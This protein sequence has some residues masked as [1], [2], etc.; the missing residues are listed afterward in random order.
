M[1]V[2]LNATDNR[3]RGG[4][5]DAGIRRPSADEAHSDREGASM[6]A[7]AAPLTAARKT[8]GR[9]AVV[10]IVVVAV[11]VVGVAA[12]T[13]LRPK[14]NANSQTSTTKVERK[15]IRVVV[16]GT[17]STVVVDSV[18]VNPQISGTVE[19][20]YVSLGET[21]TAG[22]DLYTISSPSV[23]TKLLQSKASLLQSKQSLKQSKQSHQQAKNT[24]Y[25]AKTSQIQAQQSLDNLESQAATTS[26]LENQITV[27]ERQLK[28]AK[29]AVTAAS[30]G[31]SAA[32]LGVSASQA[33]V[34]SAQQSYDDAL[35]DTKDTVV[36]APIDGVVTALPISVGS[37]VSAGTNTSSGSSGSSSSSSGGTAGA[38]TVSTGSS[39]SSSGSLTISNVGN[40]KVQVA[41]SEVDVPKL[42]IGQKAEVTF[43]AIADKLFTG[44]VALISPNGTSSSGV[45]NYDVDIT[46]DTQDPSLKPD[47]TATA[48]ILTQ[49]AENV[50]VVPNAAVKSDGKTK[51]VDAVGQNG[52]SSR[53]TVVVGVSDET[54][55]EIK[56]GLTEGAT[57]STGG[58]TGVSKTSTSGGGFMMGG[59][60]PGGGPGGN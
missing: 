21:V 42:Q 12:F 45:V 37:D 43:D 46:L 34:N 39:S 24:L 56:S 22:E 55:T 3:F 14:P 51:Y 60:P 40:L 17:G 58:A 8:R 19:K 5:T 31:V 4:T 50:L 47:M 44:T 49:V 15:T 16:S 26:G 20:L 33:N 11:I 27:A 29:S 28:S 38:T 32:S 41:V 35:A 18:T 2:A 48:D 7:E 52:S 10:A 53:V 1:A 30:T 25:S 59:G 23:E 57:I 13:I 54:S 6:S 9:W 36:T